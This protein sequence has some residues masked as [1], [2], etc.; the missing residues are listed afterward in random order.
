MAIKK[1][2]I[3]AGMHK[4]GSS[5]IQNALVN[6]SN[7]ENL[8][9][10]GYTYPRELGENHSRV[11]FNL[12]NEPMR[13]QYRSNIINGYDAKRIDKLKKQS[14]EHLKNIVCHKEA[15]TLILS[16]EDIVA[17]T[18]KELKNMKIFIQEELD[19]AD[20]K[21]ILYIRNPVSYYISATQTRA[22][23]EGET[24]DF[25]NIN[26]GEIGSY[27]TIAKRITEAF[28]EA[29]T[30]IYKFEDVL[31]QYSGPVHHFLHILGFVQEEIEK[32]EINK[33]NESQCQ[34]VVD[35]FSFFNKKVPLVIQETFNSERQRFDYSSL[36]LVKGARFDASLK[37]KKDLAKSFFGSAEYVK[38]YTSIDYV[39]DLEEILSKN[40]QKDNISPPETYRELCQKYAKLNE[41]SKQL[42]M[43]YLE[44]KKET[45]SQMSDLYHK[46]SMVYNMLKSFDE[47]N[48]AIANGIHIL[49]FFYNTGK[50][51]NEK[52]C[53]D[54]PIEDEFMLVEHTFDKMQKIRSIRID[55]DNN[56]GFIL[57]KSVKINEL[58]N[59]YKITGRNWYFKEDNTYLFLT[60]DP[61]I[62]IETEE[63]IENIRVEIL[64]DPIGELFKYFTLQ[65]FTEA[66]EKGNRK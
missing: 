48:I 13:G 64:V 29:H 12:F 43:E 36:L 25:E 27:K 55:S 62:C 39:G 54:F 59:N 11:L 14:I 31:K 23:L 40:E 1:I 52:E 44:E 6:L 3:H 15:E 30:H 41:A 5:S 47:N 19:I 46:C 49:Q 8:N 18:D 20:F 35:F 51:F 17:F 9:A 2:V 24:V 45:N 21:I 50:G 65:N 37:H 38:Q 42:F 58:E 4:T 61:Q 56:P 28:G 66:V 53:L 57:L 33:M 10:H 26:K 32:F 16:A 60:S 22:I 7:E 34:E 63:N